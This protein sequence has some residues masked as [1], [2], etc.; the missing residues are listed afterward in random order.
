M[1]YV[2]FVFLILPIEKIRQP[3]AAMLVLTIGGF[4]ALLLLFLN[5]PAVMEAIAPL[6]PQNKKVSFDAQRWLVYFSPMC[7]RLISS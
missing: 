5:L 4:V 1:L 2:F 6:V 7:G 3:A